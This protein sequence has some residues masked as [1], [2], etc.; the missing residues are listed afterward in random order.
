MKTQNIQTH[1]TRPTLKTFQVQSRCRYFHTGLVFL[2][3][4]GIKLKLYNSFLVK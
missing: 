4:I 3:I 1:V 2:L